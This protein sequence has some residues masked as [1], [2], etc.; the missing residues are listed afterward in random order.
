MG[1]VHVLGTVGCIGKGLATTF[2]LADVGTLAGV[3]TKMGLQ[4]LK[5][6]VGLATAIILCVCVCVCVCVCAYTS[7]LYVGQ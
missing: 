5:T 2:K 1:A 3:G 7:V 4:V 6:R